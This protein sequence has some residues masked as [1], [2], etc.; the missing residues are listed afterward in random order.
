MQRIAETCR[1]NENLARQ[2]EARTVKQIADK[3]NEILAQQNLTKSEEEILK[4]FE[5]YGK[6]SIILD[7]TKYDELPIPMTEKEKQLNIQQRG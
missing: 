2:I 5:H 4:E 1:N 3:H 7:L 6:I